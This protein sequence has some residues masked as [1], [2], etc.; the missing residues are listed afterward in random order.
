MQRI[1]PFD[2]VS[3]QKSDVLGGKGANLA[4]MVQMGLPVPLGFTITTKTCM[5]YLSGDEK[6]KLQLK[7]A[8]QDHVQ[9]LE[10]K[11]QKSFN[12]PH[13]L[14][15]VSVRSGAEISMPGMMDTILNL[16]LNDVTVDYLAEQTDNPCF[17]YDCYRRLLQMFGNVVYGIDSQAFERI[18]QTVRQSRGHQSDSDLSLEDLQELVSA[19][20]QVYTNQG[21]TFP[22]DPY[23]QLTQAVY[24]VFESWNNYRAKIYRQMYQI[25]DDLGTAVNVQE[26]VFG[27]FAG[28]S[29]TGVCFTRNPADGSKELYGEY[30]RNAQGEDI[31]AGIRTP[32]PI[33]DLEADLPQVYQQLLE[34]CQTLED[35]YKDMQDIEFTIEKGRLYILQTRSGKRTAQAA[36]KIACDMVKEGSLTQGEAIQRIDIQTIDQ[37]LHP[38]FS[39][40]AFD[41]GQV[42]SDKG[43]PAS[44]GAAVGRVYVDTQ[45]A[46]EA[47]KAGQEVVLVRT[48]TSPED[49][50]AM[51]L[52]QGVVTSTGGMTSH[53]AVVARGMGRSCI[54]GCVDFNID[55]EART[56]TYP[57]GCLQE[58]DEVS[59]DGSTG[60]I[61]LGRL[62]M[63]TGQQDASF[64]EMLAWAKDIADL[65]VRMNA[66]TV[67][68]IRTGMEFLADGIGL[69]RTEH[70]FFGADRLVEI[71]R[72]IL[73]GDAGERQRAMEAIR[74]YQEADFLEI[75]DLIG[76]LPV[77]IRL[78]DPPLHEFLPQDEADI[79]KVSDQLDIEAS[80]L[81]NRIKDLQ[82]TNPM[83]GHRGC[84]LAITYPELYQMQTE[85]I[86]RAAIQSNQAGGNIQ[87][88]IMIPLIGT[89][90]EMAMLRQQL[91]E[92]IHRVLEEMGAELNYT[93]GTMI[94]TPRACFIAD[95]V[96]EVSDFFSFGTN[97]L[98]QM[99]FGFSRDDANRFLFD[100]IEKGILSQDPFQT[101]DLEGVG[102]MVKIA[103][104]K[105]RAC[106]PQLKMGVCGELGGDPRSIDF[107]HEIGLDYVS[108][109]PFRIP[110]AILAAAQAKLKQS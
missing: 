99:T 76:D 37:L 23:D 87:P 34:I 77:V 43:L 4:A 57:G 53:A 55:Y 35:H 61:Y 13:Q 86:L 104:D 65:G 64:H 58:G 79:L 92:F 33:A 75:F 14:L 2:E 19:Y 60:R 74:P 47:A 26:M 68:D 46:I 10:E 20:Q 69:V 29:G 109:S 17:A 8:I 85:A 40:E 93:I 106:K 103:V 7:E 31:V 18:L 36:M 12:S 88:E 82:E 49:I 63:D 30:L 3:Q 44:P 24:A 41:T 81:R 39:Q 110:V 97:D 6:V 5:E 78:L 89:Q 9:L 71:R 95:Q 21:H 38:S 16:G 56:I 94:E 45:R 54:V 67:S 108:C 59:L 11:T 32:R 25:P 62:A 100:Y 90:A 52:A 80:V 70:M 84:R 66:E 28:D 107:F 42:I 83:L 1:Y 22:Q 51:S 27:N 50:E 48:E 91:T 102:A 96:A 105:G 15:L 73:A 101:I 72:F 98:T